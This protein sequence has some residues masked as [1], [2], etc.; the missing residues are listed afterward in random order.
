MGVVGTSV[1]TTCITTGMNTL[2]NLFERAISAY[3]NC[4]RIDFEMAKLRTKRELAFKVAELKKCELKES[5]KEFNRICKQLD[6]Q[7]SAFKLKRQDYLKT[8]KYWQRQS[9]RI[10]EAILNCSGDDAKLERLKNMWEKVTWQIE[11]AAR[12]E[13]KAILDFPTSAKQ[14]IERHNARISS[15]EHK[16]IGL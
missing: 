7:L 8:Q 16:Q 3:E 11:N 13:N 4:K 1:A 10:L 2:G 14:L 9:D 5:E 12:E 6:G 15:S